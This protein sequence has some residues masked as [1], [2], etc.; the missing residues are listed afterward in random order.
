MRREAP[1]LAITQPG[2][3]QLLR[4]TLDHL[5]SIKLL[6][7]REIII[8]DNWSRDIST[9]QILEAAKTWATE[10][11]PKFQIPRRYVPLFTI[12]AAFK[13]LRPDA[14]Y[15]VILEAGATPSKDDLSL[16]EQ[17]LAEVEKLAIAFD[18][19]QVG[20]PKT[21]LA[22][23][24]CYETLL[25]KGFFKDQPL[26]GDLPWDQIAGTMQAEGLHVVVMN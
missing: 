5:A 23:K 25:R 10:I 17:A 12:N 13:A 22:T 18:A 20:R 3:P 6:G 14:P 7:K 2:A 9:K 19:I 1:I 21:L 16:L 11:C 24:K 4:R 26:A 8:V 15:A